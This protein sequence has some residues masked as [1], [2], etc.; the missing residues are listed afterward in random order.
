MIDERMK[1]ALAFSPASLVAFKYSKDLKHYELSS[2]VL[3]HIL[4]NQNKYWGSAH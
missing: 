3:P 2:F 1:M 4:V